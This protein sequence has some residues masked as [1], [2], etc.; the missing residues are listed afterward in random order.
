MTAA[1][2]QAVMDRYVDAVRAGDWETAFG[3]F[4]D[5]IVLRVPGRS[6]LAGE[7]RGRQ[8]ARAYID[9]ALAKAH[10]QEVEVELIDR[11][12]SEQRVA[13]IVR[14][15]FARPDRDVEI[16]RAN[17]YRIAGGRIVEIWIFEAD[18]YAVDEL[19]AD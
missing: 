11:L 12:T 14:E 4:A 1:Q 6:S 15:R 18:Q 17:V 9:A 13:L 19:F 10:G 7:R 3:F 8:A 16:R 5:D 2:V